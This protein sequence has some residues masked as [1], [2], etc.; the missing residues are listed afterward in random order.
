MV[1]EPVARGSFTVISRDDG[2]KEV[3]EHI[4]FMRLAI[5]QANMAAPDDHTFNTGIMIVKNLQPISTGHS[6]DPH[7]PGLHAAANTIAKARHG[8]HAHLLVGSTMYTTM[9]P[10]S[11]P[12]V[13]KTPCTTHIINARI[14]R[15]VIGV[16]EPESFVNCKGVETLR[17]AGIDVVHMKMLQEECLK[18]NIHLLT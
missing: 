16:K 5:M 4:E 6:R 1:D 18:T 2:S 13:S 15:V 17:T 10:C 12:I 11:S 14:K 9:E 8:P 3:E 7:A